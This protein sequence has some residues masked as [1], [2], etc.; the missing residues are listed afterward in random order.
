MRAQRYGV[1]TLFTLLY[2][3]IICVSIAVYGSQRPRWGIKLDPGGPVACVVGQH[4][5]AI[6]TVRSA[7]VDPVYFLGVRPGVRICGYDGHALT[8]TTTAT[9]IDGARRLQLFSPSGCTRVAA[10]DA[11]AMATAITAF[12]TA[13]LCAVLAITLLLHGTRRRL[14]RLTVAFLSC[15][16]LTMSLLPIIWMGALF[17]TL[18]V[19]AA[20]YGAIPLLA[21]LLWQILLA[22]NRMRWINTL[23]LANCAVCG[24][25]AGLLSAA[26]AFHDDSL[27]ATII[28]VNSPVNVIDL[29]LIITVIVGGFRSRDDDH[30]TSVSLL[31][32]AGIIAVLPLFL[33]TVIPL[34][35]GQPPLLDGQ[36]SGL[37]VGMLPLALTYLALRRE[38]IAVDSLIRQTARL[39]VHYAAFVLIACC[40]LILSLALPVPLML[41]MGIGIFLMACLTPITHRG[42]RRLTESLFFP[43]VGH[44][45]AVAEALRAGTGTADIDQIAGELQSH[46]QQALPASP[47]ALFVED[48]MTGQFVA[49]GKRSWERDDPVIEALRL[50][51]QAVLQQ[52]RSPFQIFV[53]LALDRQLI[54]FLALGVREDGFPYTRHECHWLLT[55]VG[56]RTLAIDYARKLLQERL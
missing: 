12:G 28:S 15:L 30:R 25:L 17:S 41:R 39:I 3:L 54:A 22:P 44:Y 6:W 34:L 40:D 20:T 45:R 19:I 29:A 13:I 50:Q 8:T 24:I 10:Q 27:L 51:P 16:L 9:E 21:L 35:I 56:Y 2:V 33:L 26:V 23:M 52:H 31:S 32:A 38:L 7:A 37:T 48:Q 5:S 1:A 43:E 49:C 4:C 53:P 36:F 11:T 55:L 46:I 18:S 42:L 14:V 47:L